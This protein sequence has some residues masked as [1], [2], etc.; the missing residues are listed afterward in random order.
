[1]HG[2]VN[3]FAA[4]SV[5][6]YT[7]RVCTQ[8]DGR[9]FDPQCGSHFDRFEKRKD[10]ESSN[11]AGMPGPFMS[12]KQNEQGAKLTAGSKYRTVRWL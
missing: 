2:G 11:R 12:Q 6:Q 5:S 4:I 10:S 9:A 8:R 7:E 1:M 3:F